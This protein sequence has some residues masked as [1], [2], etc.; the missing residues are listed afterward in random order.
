MEEEVLQT[1]EST[2]PTETTEPET[3]D[4]SGV[5]VMSNGEKIN[6]ADESKEE[7]SSD[8]TTDEGSDV[9]ED[10]ETQEET[11]GE[12]QDPQKDY[13]EAQSSMA[14]AKETLEAKGIDYNALQEEYNDKGG[15]STVSYE[16]LE[17][18]GYPK[19]VVDA[20]I[21]GWQAKADQFTDAVITKAGGSEAYTRLTKFVSSQGDAAINA[22]NNIVESG[23][24]NTINAYLAGVKA[25][26]EAKYGTANPTL[27]GGNASVKATSG[28][29]D[30][31]ELIKAMSDK[32]YGRDAK[33]T[34]EVEN[35]IA[36]SALFA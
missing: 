34:R 8:E 4:L 12:T 21:D 5:E 13:E 6:V 26:M 11:E 35:R 3:P 14:S 28:F 23:D 27:M 29:T 22:F 9:S 18:A 36:N 19:T 32:R 17:K 30:Q 25:Q 1:P 31:N 16:A 15:L 7:D 24:F 10:A 2:T 33:Y 20:I